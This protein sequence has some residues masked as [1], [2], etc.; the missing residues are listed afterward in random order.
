MKNDIFKKFAWVIGVVALA[1]P[2]MAQDDTTIVNRREKKIIVIHKTHDSSDTEERDTVEI[3]WNNDSIIR[4][5]SNKPPGIISSGNINLGFANVYKPTDYVSGQYMYNAF[6]ELKNGN[7]M[8]VGLENN[9]GF[10]MIKGKLRFWMGLRYDIMSYRFNNPDVRLFEEKAV[11]T[12]AMDSGSNSVKSKVVVN[13]IGIPVSI[14]Y[15]SNA[16]RVEDGFFIRAGVN[17][18]Y[19]VRTHS[20]VKFENGNK[21]KVFDDFNF[22]DIA[23]T[24]FVYVGYN[25]LG[26]Y[27]RYTTTPVFKEGQ[28]EEAYAVQFGIILQ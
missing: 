12:T 26:F 22:S 17:G 3:R 8:H 14:G 1:L 20:K 10:N 7:S 11:F 4:T 9:W 15:Q 27:A 23:I 19:R 18:G 25:S 2:A 13:Y 16:R 28:G 21:D 24:P 5:Y 6:P